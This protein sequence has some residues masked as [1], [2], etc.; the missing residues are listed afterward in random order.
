MGGGG[1][2]I[3]SHMTTC[4]TWTYQLFR[5]SYLAIYS[6]IFS[7]YRNAL[8]DQNILVTDFKTFRKYYLL[9]SC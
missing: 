9:E 8:M 4:F 7:L 3:R 5:L 1:G 2:R 6:L